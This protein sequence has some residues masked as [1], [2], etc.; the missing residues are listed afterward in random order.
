MELNES[1]PFPRFAAFSFYW[2]FCPSNLGLPG[3]RFKKNK[4]K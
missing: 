1:P 4:S 3:D 2:L